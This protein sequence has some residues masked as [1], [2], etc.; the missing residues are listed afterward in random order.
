[1]S[2][3]RNNTL[4]TAADGV[5]YANSSTG[6]VVGNYGIIVI[7]EDGTTFSS[8]IQPGADNI[9]IAEGL[10][11]SKGEQIVG[12]TAGFNVSSGTVGAVKF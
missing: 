6:L 10:T 9:S 12:T 4:I 2:N 1:M 5:T 7:Y 3:P 11:Y 8:L